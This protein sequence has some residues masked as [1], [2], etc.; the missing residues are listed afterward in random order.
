MSFWPENEPARERIKR[1]LSRVADYLQDVALLPAL[2]GHEQKMA[3]YMKSAFEA[4]RLHIETDTFGNCIATC[5]GTEQSAPGIMIF[6]HMDSLGFVVRY[7]EPDGF[8][9]LER[10]GGIPEKVLPATQVVVTCRDGRVLPGVIGIKQHHVT[11]PEEKYVVDKYM[12]LFVDIGARSKEEVLANGIDIGS[13]I[14]YKPTFQRL[15]GTKAALSWGDNRGGC[16]VLLELAHLLNETPHACTVYLVGTVQEEFNLRGAM[17][18]T[19]TA[20]PHIA[21][22]LDCGGNA[23]TPDLFGRGDVRLGAG[24][25]MFLYNFHGRGTLNG[26]IG[27][28]AMIWLAEEAALRKAIPLQRTASIGVLT[29]LSYAQ[30]E[31]TGLKAVDLGFPLRYAHSPHEV[32]DIK[33]L[34]ALGALVADL[35]CHIDGDTGFDR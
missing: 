13:P 2:S 8:L 31:G 15:R 33:D 23:D 28:P 30:L 12:S 7:I 22:G 18:A 10:L 26:T 16:A 29:D 20:K 14:V 21:I 11:P 35:V 25:T 3:E 4:Q 27:H 19:R 6:A 9:R 24:P 1:M 34:D 32:L 5:P 17:M